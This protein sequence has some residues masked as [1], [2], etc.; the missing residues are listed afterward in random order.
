[1]TDIL[2]ENSAGEGRYETVP[3]SFGIIGASVQ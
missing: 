3:R 2:Q 1:M